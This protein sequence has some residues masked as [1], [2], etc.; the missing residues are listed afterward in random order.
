M[1]SVSGRLKPCRAKNTV[2]Q[3]SPKSPQPCLQKFDC[4]FGPSSL[5]LVTFLPSN[6]L[7][8]SHPEVGAFL[9]VTLKDALGVQRSER[10]Q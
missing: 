9:K 2:A 6:A 10:C 1:N 3:Y 7:G 4:V 8:W 5:V